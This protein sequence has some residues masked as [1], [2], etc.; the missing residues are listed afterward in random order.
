MIRP[1]NS[2]LKV[3]VY[4]GVVDM[5][6]QIDGQAALVETTMEVNPFSKRLVVFTN[7]RRDKLKILAWDKNGF[8]VWYER[9]EKQRFLRL[10][11]DHNRVLS[12]KD[13]NLYLDGY[14]INRFKPHEPLK[15]EK[16]A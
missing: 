1:S 8:L 9:L 4:S 15:I 16:V 14:D 11:G 5:R 2:S 3:Y 10:K 7:K 12:I 13:L 6:K